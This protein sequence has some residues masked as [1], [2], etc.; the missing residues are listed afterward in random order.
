MQELSQRR[1]SRAEVIEG[2]R[3]IIVDND[4][5]PGDRLPSLSE[6]SRRL[7]AGSRSVREAVTTLE[8]RGL[9]ETHQGKGVFLKSTNLEF[10]L[11]VLN[12]SL[13]FD[14]SRDRT[15]LLELTDVRRMIESQVIHDLAE[16]PAP[17]VLKELVDIL[18]CME[19]RAAAHA[20]DDYNLLDM[21]FHQT[22]VAGS[23]N[24]ILI[25]L[26]RY[27]A[28]LLRRSIVRTGYMQGSLEQSLGDHRQL[29]EALIGRDPERARATMRRHLLKTRQRLQELIGAD[30]G[31]EE[32]G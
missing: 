14:L 2:I 28:G 9:L 27:L 15:R 3:Q 5:Q 1:R 11:E 22:I 16:R 29:L 31:G 18:D 23:G 13:S 25:T 32:G 19:E 21:R 20:V 10:F 4:L 6:L 8:A 12:D 30:A 24:E 26:Y 17:A 7:Q